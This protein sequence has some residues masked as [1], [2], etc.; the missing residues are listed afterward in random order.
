[1]RH[2]LRIIRPHL[3]HQ[4]TRYQQSGWTITSRSITQLRIFTQIRT[5]QQRSSLLPFGSMPTILRQDQEASDSWITTLDQRSLRGMLH[6][7]RYRPVMRST[8]LDS[9]HLIAEVITIQ[10]PREIQST[11]HL[12]Y[13]CSHG[14]VGLGQELCMELHKR[15]ECSI[16]TFPTISM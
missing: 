10:F 7:Q 6:P 11:S 13:L 8:G 16:T 2:K 9:Y 12:R 5:P 1:M 4:A 3:I 14:A 15:R